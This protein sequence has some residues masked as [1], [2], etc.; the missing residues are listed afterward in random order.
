VRCDTA[1]VIL[2]KARTQIVARDEGASLTLRVGY[3]AGFQ[4][5]LE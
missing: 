5:A 3:D 2:A 4:S 1:A